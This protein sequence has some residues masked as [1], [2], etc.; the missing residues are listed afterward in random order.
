MADMSGCESS[1][2]AEG[3]ERKE[4]RQGKKS[5]AVRG[6]CI[7]VGAKNKIML[8]GG[9]TSSRVAV[10]S[11]VASFG[12]DI[13]DVSEAEGEVLFLFN[14]PSHKLMLT[15]DSLHSYLAGLRCCSLH[16]YLPLMAS[17]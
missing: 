11:S 3:Q 17:V 6:V 7:G 9:V 10:R 16:K 5:S 4:E 2:R 13:E 15:S 8:S 14:A 12:H 1:V